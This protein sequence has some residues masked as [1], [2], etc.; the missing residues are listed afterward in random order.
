MQPSRC[1]ATKM[2]AA[3]IATESGAHMVI[4]NA[5]NLD[6]IHQIVDGDDVGTWIQ[7]HKNPDFYL[8]DYFEDD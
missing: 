6:V 1:S 5:A 7:A 3:H 8:S 4:A 2:Q